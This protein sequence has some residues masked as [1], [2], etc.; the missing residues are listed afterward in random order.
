MDRTFAQPC[1]PHLLSFTIIC[2]GFEYQSRFELYS[3][4]QAE[5]SFFPLSLDFLLLPLSPVIMM[6]RAF[7][8][9]AEILLGHG[10]HGQYGHGP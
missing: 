10:I 4:G 1:T 5:P 8:V 9:A 3:E 7:D 2:D 6:A